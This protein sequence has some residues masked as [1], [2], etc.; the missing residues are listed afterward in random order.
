MAETAELPTAS[1]ARRR[2]QLCFLLLLQGSLEAVF[3]TQEEAQGGLL[4][5]R[6][7]NSFLEEMW[8]GSLEREC[9][10]EW[11]SLEEAREIFR[12]PEKTRDFWTSY[13]DGDQCASNPCQNGGSCEDQLQ[14]YICFCPQDFEGRNCETNKTAQLVC[15]NENGGCAQYCSDH[16]GDKRSCRCHEGY[17]L[18]PDGVSCAPTV[19][20]PCGKIPILEKRNA[21]PQGRIVGGKVCPKGECPWQAVLLVNGRLLCGGSLLDTS[22]VVSAAHCFDKIRSWRN[23]SVVLGEHDLG[24][25]DGDEQVR[26]VAQ[27]IFPDKYARGS[28]DHD[29]VLLR[30]HRPV[31]LTDHVVPLC[32]PERAFSE[33]ALASVRFS[34]VSGWGQLLDRGATARELMA[35]EVPR[36]KTQDCLEQARPAPGSPSVT[37]RM[38]CAGYLEGGRDS[39]KGDSGGPHATH[40]R[41]TWYLTG[42]V[43][44]GEGCAAVGRV[45]VYTRVSVYAEW[46]RRLM[47]SERRPPV[48]RAPRCLCPEHFTPTATENQILV[49]YR[50]QGITREAE[51][52]KNQALSAAMF[53]DRPR[54]HAVLVRTRRANSFLE[55]WKKGNLEREC[56][57][58]KCVYEE[59]REVFENTEKTG[60][61]EEGHCSSAHRILKATSRYYHTGT[62]VSTFES[63]GETH[64]TT[65]DNDA[66]RSRKVEFW[67]KYKDGDQCESDPCQNQGQCKDGIGGYMCACL[68]GFEGKNCELWPQSHGGTQQGGL[69]GRVAVSRKHCNLDNGDCD[70]FC[71]EEPNLVVC[72]CASGY[73][74]DNNGKSCLSTEPFPCGKLTSGLRKRSVARATGS[75]ERVSATSV[76]EWDSSDGLPPT[77]S[78]YYFLDHNDT[79]PETNGSDRGRIVGGRNCRD[80]EC[81]WQALLVNEENEGFCGGTILSEYHILTAAHCLHQAKR[82][83]VRVG[84]RDT[85][86]EEGNEASHEVAA[87]IK[88]NR[89]VLETY[90]FDIAVLRL[91]T[92]I[93][94]RRNVAPACLPRRDWAEATLMAQKTGIVSG[95]GRT[96]EKGRLS[97][98]LKMLEVPYVDRNTCKLSS[99]F[100]ITQN[101]FCAGYDAELEDACQGDSGGPHV[102]R[103]RDTYFVTGIVSWGEGCARKGKYGV[104]TKV[105][106]FLR[107]IERSMRTRVTPG[108]AMPAAETPVP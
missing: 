103:F 17:E 93:T 23:M 71:Q 86:K 9:R 4:R 44:W 75:S 5:R 108:A 25:R 7:A 62:E 102:T 64:L 53:I 31:N 68:E 40:Y 106:A 101:M 24:Q 66:F 35:V 61:R 27:I 80:G 63:G 67:N 8:P 87:I 19:E 10:E 60:R 73:T 42:V 33:S 47:G 6:R 52:G 69:Q 89:F 2:A 96:H 70:Q 20:Y 21:N 16:P 51:W 77:E 48:L 76:P 12:T 34:R 15:A 46:L 18:L 81:P 39:C 54:A 92:P 65:L 91:R 72:S 36:L 29:V 78:P 56:V 90:D 83:T 99:S 30:L 14:S 79:Y 82:F 13:S 85:E 88:H 49:H 59:A 50:A 22:W 28:I 58:E 3:L 32:L 26:R 95:F 107:W 74:L 97:N 55:E 1:P 37:E 38:F 84:D 94:F 100:T 105:A 57:E 98:T 43:S 45:G 41:G 104:Y 11:C